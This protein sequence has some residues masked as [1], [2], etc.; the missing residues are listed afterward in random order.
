MLSTVCLTLP[1]SS[2]ALLLLQLNTLPRFGTMDNDPRVCLL[3]SAESLHCLISPTI[4][5]YADTS[6][7]NIS[8]RS[9]FISRHLWMTSVDNNTRIHI[10]FIRRDYRDIFYIVL[11]DASDAGSKDMKKRFCA[12]QRSVFSSSS[13]RH[14]GARAF[15]SVF[16]CTPS[17]LPGSF[18]WRPGQS[19]CRFF[20]TANPKWWTS[21]HSKLLPELL[22]WTTMDHDGLWWTMM[23]C[24]CVTGMRHRSPLR[25]EPAKRL[26]TRRFKSYDPAQWLWLC[27]W[28]GTRRQRLP[29]CY[30]Y[31][32][33]LQVMLTC[34][35]VCITHVSH[36]QAWIQE[37]GH[38]KLI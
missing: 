25:L 10:I 23:D 19:S 24:S 32:K 17:V 33:Y 35:I 28:S 6:N 11:Y 36:V 8:T 26:S 22:A 13:D 38:M 31:Y 21:N 18:S 7:L 37:L 1:R 14:L 27:Q 30:L 9:L 16:F 4:W 12:R 2:R 15:S 3:R 29:A 34:V 5:P 20:T